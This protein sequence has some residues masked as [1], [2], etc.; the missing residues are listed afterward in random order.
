MNWAGWIAWLGPNAAQ[1]APPPWLEDVRREQVAGLYRNLLVGMMSAWLGA[2]VLCVLFVQQ[3]AVAKAVAIAWFALISALTLAR[4]VLAATYTRS[5]NARAEWRAWAAWFTTGCIVSGFAWGLGTL[6]FMAPGRFDLQLLIVLTLSALVYGGLAS[7]GRWTPAFYG[8]FFPAMA[9]S[10]VWSLLQG[11]VVHL[12]YSLLAALWIPS[13]ALLA[14][15]FGNGVEQALALGFEN[16]A[17]AEDLRK[18]KQVADDANLA[19]S[20]F[21]AAASHDLRQPVHALGLLVGALRHEKLAP[22][23]AQLV[24]QIDTA[25]GSLDELFTSLLDVSRLDAGVVQPRQKAIALRPMLLRLAAELRPTAEAKG[26][27][28]K[29]RAADLWVRSDAVMLER[30]IRNL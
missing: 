15:R 17:L 27:V 2:A 9:P 29:L 14:Q 7:F 24:E 25:T 28:L 5:A 13:V 8:F 22:E 16:A 12:A 1:P 6:F 10:A 3:H 19:K 21:L 26:L 4:V 20:R 23:A 18:Q 11:D 30:V